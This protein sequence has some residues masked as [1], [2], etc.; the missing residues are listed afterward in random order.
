MSQTANY[1]N[2][3]PYI[4][5]RTMNLPVKDVATAAEFYKMAMNFREVSR[6]S[7]PHPAVILERDDIRIGIEENGGDPEQEGCFFEVDNVEAALLELKERGLA[8]QPSAIKPHRQGDTNW[9]MF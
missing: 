3:S 9:R 8:I 7:D 6:T 1:K 2:V 5:G 4:Q